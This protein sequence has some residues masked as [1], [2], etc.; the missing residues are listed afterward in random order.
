MDEDD[1]NPPHSELT[2]SEPISSTAA[3][4]QPATTSEEDF[5]APSYT[6]LEKVKMEFANQPNVFVSFF[7]VCLKRSRIKYTDLTSFYIL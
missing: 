3:M 5:L 4:A 2:I 1:L 7:A 6:F